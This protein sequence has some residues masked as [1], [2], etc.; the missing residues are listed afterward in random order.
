MNFNQKQ[1]KIVKVCA[2][3]IALMLIFPPF[4]YAR[5]KSSQSA[6]YSFIMDAPRSTSSYQTG[7]VDIATLLTQWIGVVLIG[8]FLVA[9]SKEED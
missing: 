8:G 3:V 2:V 4:E 7:Q 1:I 6:G 9:V 5:S